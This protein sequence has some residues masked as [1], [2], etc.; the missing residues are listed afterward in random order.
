VDRIKGHNSDIE[1]DKNTV[2][3]DIMQVPTENLNGVSGW[4]LGLR[5]L[6][7]GARTL[8][9]HLF[10]LQTVTIKGYVRPAGK[11]FGRPKMTKILSKMT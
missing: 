10:W 8:V 2:K 9:N 7:S 1:N 11:F 4:R 6:S 3:N 5:P